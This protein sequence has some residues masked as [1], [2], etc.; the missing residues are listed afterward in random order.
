MVTRILSIVFFLVAIYLGY[1]LFNSVKSKIDDEKRI[2]RVE[3]NVIEKLK[4]IRDTQIAYQMVYGKYTS[5]WDS[6][7]S[8]LD[9]GRIYITERTEEIIQKEY[10]GEE[11]ILHVDTVGTQPAIDYVFTELYL[12]NAPDTGII[13]NINFS[14]G[15]VITK[16]FQLYF[17]QTD[18]KLLK[19]R[20][21]YVGE[22]TAIYVKNGD[23]VIKAQTLGEVLF[24]K[25]PEGTNISRLAYIPGSNNKFDI[26]AAEIERSGVWVDVFEVKDVDPVN[27]ER[28]T[29]NNE[30]ALRIGSR[31]DVTTAGNWE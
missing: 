20:S 30:K 25:Y 11:V 23:K 31:T 24:Y 9:S 1:F 14:V 12:I 4:L 6:L 7:I 15:D 3:N 5:D 19:P 18:E 22:I 27:P 16:G 10:G 26:Y 29:N 2:A 17:L 8:F 21:E 28:K 13:S